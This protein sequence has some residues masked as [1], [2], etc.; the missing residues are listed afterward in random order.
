VGGGATLRDLSRD[1][2]NDASKFLQHLRV[3]EAQGQVAFATQDGT[4]NF[5]VR[6]LLCKTVLVA[7]DLDDNFCAVLDEIEKVASERNLSAEVI[8]TPVQVAKLPPQQPL[9][10]GSRASQFACA[11]DR[12]SSQSLSQCTLH[13]MLSPCASIDLPTRGRSS[14]SFSAPNFGAPA[15]QR[16]HRLL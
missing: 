5:I 13:P 11:P 12:V 14:L 7:I 16:E 2:F 10:I 6:S 9:S 8:A 4:A 1:D 15:I 3:C